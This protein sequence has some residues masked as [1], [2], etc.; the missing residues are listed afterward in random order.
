MTIEMTRRAL[1][2]WT[3]A[4]E[5]GEYDQGVGT[6]R[7][8]YVS[9]EKDRFCCL[10]V[11]CDVM[12]KNGLEM[13]VKKNAEDSLKSMHSWSYGESGNFAGLPQE[14]LAATGFKEYADPEYANAHTSRYD[15]RYGLG[16]VRL[17]NWNDSSGT[18]H[19]TFPEIAKVLREQVVVTG[20]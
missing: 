9:P 5:S 10:G 15:P 13:P 6:L 16:Q 7:M 1:D 18:D 17:I 4:L 20:D 14:V 19:L 8:T 11:L 12:L 2:L 3:T